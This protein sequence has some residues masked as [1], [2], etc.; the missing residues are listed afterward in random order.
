MAKATDRKMSEANVVLTLAMAD[1]MSFD[2]LDRN[3]D[4]VLEAVEQHAAK[5]ALGPTITL[6]MKQCAIL[7]RFDVMATS[8]AMV[9]RKIATVLSVIEKHT[10]LD[11]TRSASAVE[12]SDGELIEA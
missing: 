3:S 4:D 8:E 10:D 9:Y 2:V 6:S 5:V 12:A 11:F 1:P 7:L